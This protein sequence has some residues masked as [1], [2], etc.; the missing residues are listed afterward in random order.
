MCDW[1]CTDEMRVHVDRWTQALLDGLGDAAGHVAASG[2][3]VGKGSSKK[4]PKSESKDS[5]LSL[6][7]Q[8]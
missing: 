1:L 5:A 7:A 6:F 8:A 2:S 3:D 4:K